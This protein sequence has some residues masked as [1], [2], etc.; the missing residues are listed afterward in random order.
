MSRWPC[1]MNIDRY[2][3]MFLLVVCRSGGEDANV[4]CDKMPIS[5]QDDAV[6]TVIALR[7][8]RLGRS[9]GDSRV[10]DV[11]SR[12]GAGEIFPT[13]AKLL[14]TSTKQTET[15]KMKMNEPHTTNVEEIWS[16]VERTRR[17]VSNRSTATK[18]SRGITRPRHSQTDGKRSWPTNLAQGTDENR[19]DQTRRDRL[20]APC[21][22]CITHPRSRLTA[23]GRMIFQRVLRW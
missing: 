7:P 22:N 18:D 6:S 19:R 3:R 14:K 2:R 4:L 9:G 11:E 10:S 17:R 21:I 20:P 8:A 13:W 5:K 16:R 1:G 15:T 23:G 12:R